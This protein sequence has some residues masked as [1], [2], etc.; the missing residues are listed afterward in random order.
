MTPT[1]DRPPGQ[2]D[3]DEDDDDAGEHSMWSQIDL[4]AK[5]SPA[6]AP[7]YDVDAMRLL[8]TLRT[9][10]NTIFYDLHSTLRKEAS[11]TAPTL[12]VLFALA[13]HGRLELADLPRMMGISRASASLLVATMRDEGLV[14]T[15]AA[16]GDKRKLVIEASPAGHAAFIE[17]I[18]VFNRR[19]THWAAGLTA[20]EQEQLSALIRK[21]VNFRLDEQNLRTR[22]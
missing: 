18:T 9:A 4:A 6:W 5:V 8:M 21:L 11:I 13:L 17:A 19:E 14:T 12:Q 1:R 7:G 16:D 3:A 15:E 20:S 10:S 2:N 22:K